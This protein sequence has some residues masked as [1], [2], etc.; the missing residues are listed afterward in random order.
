M[1]ASMPFQD[2]GR[3]ARDGSDNSLDRNRPFPDAQARKQTDR[4]RKEKLQQAQETG[5]RIIIDLAF[6]DKMT[7]AELRSMCQQLSYSYSANARATKPAHLILTGYEVT[8]TP[9]C[10]RILPLAFH[11]PQG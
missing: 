10:L 2:S 1:S 5:Q 7:G 9:P 11:A 3:Q 8:S 6:A 4:E